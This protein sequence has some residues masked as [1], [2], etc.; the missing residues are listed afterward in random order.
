MESSDEQWHDRDERLQ[1]RWSKLGFQ[2]LDDDEAFLV[3]AYRCWQQEDGPVSLA[4]HRSSLMDLLRQDRLSTVL[5]DLLALFRAFG[6]DAAMNESLQGFPLLTWREERLLGVLG[7]PPQTVS[8]RCDDEAARCR[9]GLARNG[10]RLRHPRRI[11]RC[12]RDL[13]ELRIARSFGAH[14]GP[15]GYADD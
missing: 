12:G 11:P 13:L 15:P 9:V 3:W 8:A 6:P 4:E 5:P 7:E 14:W 1:P 2:D 10:V